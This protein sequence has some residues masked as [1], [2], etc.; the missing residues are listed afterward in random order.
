MSDD[1]VRGAPSTD[2]FSFE[3]GGE[4]SVLRQRSI[5]LS[6]SISLFL[7]CFLLA[8][9]SSLFLLFFRS[10]V[11][12]FSYHS[13]VFFGLDPLS[14][15]DLARPRKR[16]VQFVTRVPAREIIHHSSIVIFVSRPNT[17]SLSLFLFL[18]CSVFRENKISACA[19]T[20]VRESRT[21]VITRRATPAADMAQ[22]YNHQKRNV[23][24]IDQILGHPKDEGKISTRPSFFREERG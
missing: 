24:S 10:L 1:P 21:S 6:L 8:L 18:P 7:S 16:E 12:S 9:R 20:S 23:Y 3:E 15:R 4:R 11:C 22:T 2:A 13:R 19:L 17:S 5:Y 14:T